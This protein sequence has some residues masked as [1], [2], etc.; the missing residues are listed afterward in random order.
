MPAHWGTLTGLYWMSS[1]GKRGLSS[2]YM[3]SPGKGSS[4][5]LKTRD[6]GYG[7]SMSSLE[8]GPDSSGYSGSLENSDYEQHATRDYD[9][10]SLDNLSLPDPAL[11]CEP[12]LLYDRGEDLVC[13]D[14]LTLVELLLSETHIPELRC[15]KLVVSGRFLAR[16]GRQLQHL[17]TT[18]P[19]GLKGALLD[20]YVEHG[21]AVYSI[22][23]LTAD[24]SVVP[25]FRLN[26][27]FVLEP[28]LWPRIQSLFSAPP[29]ITPGFGQALK[30]GPGFRVL[31]KKLY[32]SDELHDD[33]DC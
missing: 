25:T 8:S 22:G 30:L 11:I 20:M 28:G 24:P 9:A 7:G 32:S 15:S 23:Q 18:E 5:T 27:I 10:E 33:E 14:L 21:K 26:L 12:E 29:A 6:S 4:A 2:A 19:C 16:V 13:C 31:K 3:D 1:R 17:S